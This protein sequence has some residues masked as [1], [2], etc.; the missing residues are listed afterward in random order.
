MIDYLKTI[1]RSMKY[2]PFYNGATGTSAGISTPD[3]VI[4]G[5]GFASSRALKPASND[6][7]YDLAA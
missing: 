3:A 7:T 6:E 1:Y 4:W 5:V 2:A